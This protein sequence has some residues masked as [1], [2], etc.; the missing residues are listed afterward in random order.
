MDFCWNGAPVTL[1]GD[2]STTSSL[3][4][5]NQLQALVHN[6]GIS[7]LFAL[8]PVHVLGEE[9][10][11][12]PEGS[13]F[14]LPANLTEPFVILLHTYRNLFLPPTASPPHHTIDH[15]IHLLPNTTLVNVRPYRYPHFQKNEMEKLIREML[16]QGIIRP[17]QSLFSL[18]VL[19]VKKKDGTYRFCVDYRALN[20][21]S[22]KDKFLIPTIDELFDELGG[23]ATFT[24]LDLR[25]AYHQIRVHHRDIYKTTFRTHEGHYAF[26][27]VPFGLTDASFTFQATMNQIFASFLRKFVIVFFMTFWFIVL[28]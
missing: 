15:K 2:L 24:K 14:E 5:L 1:R 10:A 11:H 27:V 18:P 17:S 7:H 16:E 4:T 25:A 23:A 12:T 9:S 6:A 19:L 21:V 22:I 28:Q 8:Q 26:L 3:I 20:A 13:P